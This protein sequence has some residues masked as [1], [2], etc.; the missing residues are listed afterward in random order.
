MDKHLLDACE[1][2]DAALFTGD[3][4][5]SK[6]SR[7]KLCAYMRR[8]LGAFDTLPGESPIRP[9][10]DDDDARGNDPSIIESMP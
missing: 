2:I 10:D 6:E 1:T 7:A 5:N 9:L 8:W 3:V 4:L